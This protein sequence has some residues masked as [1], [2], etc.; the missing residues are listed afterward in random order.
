LPV[1]A[2]VAAGYKWLLGPYG[3]GFVYLN[4]RIQDRLDL[5]MVNWLTV[6]NSED[7]DALPVDQFMLPHTAQ[8]F[9]VPET[10]NFLNLSGL[11][12]SL[13]FIQRASVRTVSKHCERLLDHLA[14]GVRRLGFRLSA[15]AEPDLRSTILCFQADSL[16]KTI[17]LAEELR[18][19]EI[20]VSLRRGMIRV[21]PYLYNT[22]AD[23]DRVL[24]IVR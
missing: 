19:N 22:E 6:E 5:Q 23:I 8:V 1:D 4:P 24:E 11:D 17:S 9:D 16:E 15:A 12:A 21:S 3:T 10:A 14:E 7:F 2:L 13:E 18:A 20:A